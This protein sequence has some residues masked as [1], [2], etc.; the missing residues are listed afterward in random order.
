MTTETT[1][2]APQTTEQQLVGRPYVIRGGQVMA[3]SGAS[4]CPGCGGV[5]YR[6]ERWIEWPDGRTQKLC[7]YDAGCACPS[8]I[9]P[10]PKTP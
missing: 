5:H 10:L 6:T 2:V 3:R 9:P 7:A 8:N 4:I 1:E